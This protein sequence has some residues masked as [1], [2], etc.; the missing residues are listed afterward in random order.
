MNRFILIIFLLSFIDLHCQVSENNAGIYAKEFSKDISLFKAKAYLMDNIL[1]VNN[2]ET[3][4]EAYALAASNSGE[5]TSLAYKCDSK[6][7]EGL[8]LGFYGEYWNNN[9]VVFQGYSF[10]HFDK[11]TAIE[12]FDKIDKAI[13]NHK[14]YLMQDTDNNNVS[15]S[16]HDIDVL[17]YRSVSSEKIRLFWNGFDAMWESES[18]NKTKRRFNKKLK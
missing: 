3:I 18:Y 6:G 11:D 9:G 2:S 17:I 10:K 16:F 13:E 12:F 1:G 15:F 8:I 5:I 7:K 14:K 4:F